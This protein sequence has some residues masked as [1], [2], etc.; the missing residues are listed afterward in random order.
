MLNAYFLETAVKRKFGG[1]AFFRG[2]CKKRGGA[3]DVRKGK[4]T[5]NVA[6]PRWN[7]SQRR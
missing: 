1:P 4:E 3:G 6:L 5:R 7:L 2:W